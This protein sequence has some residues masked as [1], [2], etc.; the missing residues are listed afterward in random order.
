M[1]RQLIA[2]LSALVMVCGPASAQQGYQDTHPVSQP[3]S[4]TVE[5][6]KPARFAHNL[7]LGD[8]GAKVKDLQGALLDLGFGVP[9]G[10]T[11]Y[12][13]QQT[14]DAVAAF[15]SSQNLRVTGLFDQATR[16]KLQEVAPESGVAVWKQTRPGA[17]APQ[18]M[19]GNKPVRALVDL[20]E[21]RVTVYKQDGTV[22]RVFPVASGAYGTPTDTGLKMVYD[23]VADPTP[24]AWK[25]WPESA[26]RAFGDRMLDLSWYDANTGAS[27]DSGEEMHGTDARNSIGSNASHGCIRLYNENIQWLYSNLNRGDLIL[28]QN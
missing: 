24:I 26:G 19:A 13:G 17:V 28:V 3:A 21:H 2:C 14:K 27:W 6:A 23:K 15:Q 20:S 25:L 7:T 9:A 4:Q 10:A 12:Y 8:E 18:P 22:D 11:G 5:V 16:K 1:K